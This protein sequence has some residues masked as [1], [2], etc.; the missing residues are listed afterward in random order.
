MGYLFIASTILFTVY[1][2]LIIKFRVNKYG[3]LPDGLSEKMSYMLHLLIDP[4]I[5]SGFLS[6]FI[7]SFF[8]MAALTKFDIS[9]AYPFMSLSF[10]LVFVLSIIFFN[11][12]FT[13]NKLIGIGFIIL[14]IIF[15]AK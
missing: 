12:P 14:G 5:L 6:A 3:P 9:H 13:V 1:G 10:V 4:L 2:Q 7:A 15:I 11:E 8:W